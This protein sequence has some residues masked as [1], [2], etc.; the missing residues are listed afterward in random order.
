M[1]EEEEE[2]NWEEGEGWEE[3]DRR[4]D[5]GGGGGVVPRPAAHC[6]LF[7]MRRDGNCEL[8]ASLTFWRERNL[9]S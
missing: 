7:L 6:R 5:C 4:P 2:D 3:R 8:T 1:E 9:A